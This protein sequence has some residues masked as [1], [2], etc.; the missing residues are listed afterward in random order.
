M[1]Q[2][3]DVE[4]GPIDFD[5]DVAWADVVDR[6]VAKKAVVLV[7]N[8]Q[9]LIERIRQ[10]K[11][12]ED[13]ELRGREAKDYPAQKW[14]KVI[15]E[16]DLVD[17]YQAWCEELRKRDIP[18]LL[19]MST[20]ARYPAIAEED[21]LATIADGQEAT[22]D[23]QASAYSREQIAEMV[24]ERRFGYHRV[25]LPFGLHTRGDDRSETRDLV[26]PPSLA[27]KSVLDVGCAHGYFSFEAEARGAAR[28]VGVEL[29]EDRFRDAL[30]LKD[31]KGSKVEFIQRDIVRDPLDE[32]FDHVLLLNVVHHLKD[33]IQAMRQLASITRERLVIEFPTLED[34][35]FQDS[36]DVDLPSGHDTLPLI[37]VSSMRQGVGQTFVFTPSAVKRMLL[38]HEPL[39]EDVE[40]LSSPLPGRAIAICHKGK[41]RD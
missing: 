30:L 14:L 1:K 29:R 35:K 2:G 16:V 12:I 4:V 17:L 5:Q 18:Y 6:D 39:F 33:P 34:R 28:V 24:R 7:A 27:G 15:E 10:R 40:I 23:G 13:P 31:I 32:A 21:L 37:G 11:R 41:H 20:D 8:K 3:D 26:L 22:E 36:L 25:D 19:V 38:D 9:T